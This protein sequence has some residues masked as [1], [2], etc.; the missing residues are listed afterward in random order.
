MKGLIK[1]TLSILLVLLC[2]EQF[3]GHHQNY[4]RA[5]SD[6]LLLKLEMLKKRENDKLV[7]IGS[8]KTLDAVD[9]A[10]FNDHFNEVSDK[11][12]KSFNMATTGQNYKRIFHTIKKVLKSQVKVLVIETSYV[13][14][15]DGNLG[16]DESE[17]RN[18]NKSNLSIEED[19]Q[20]FLSRN[21]HMVRL[22]KAF[23]PKSFLRLF[24]IFSSNIFNHDMWFRSNT[25]KQIISKFKVVQDFSSQDLIQ[26]K[27]ISSNINGD[28][29]FRNLINLL[30]TTEKKII[31]INP[32]VAKEDHE[33]ECNDENHH[34]YKTLSKELDT[35]VY[36]YTCSAFDQKFMRDPT[37]LNSSG[38]SA[39][40][41]ILVRDLQKE[42]EQE[43]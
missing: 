37:H 10:L 33:R 22:R 2:T 6:K 24:M 7:F 34:S 13:N 40:T 36:D 16:F 19:V 42:I 1:Y 9:S 23:K 18:I 21:L 11:K 14:F 27:I 29:R 32:P 41:K 5:L 26:P 25:I 39:F 8:S 30:D 17:K 43:I 35:K 20:G 15:L 31:F 12:M 28:E 3:V 4:F 38:R